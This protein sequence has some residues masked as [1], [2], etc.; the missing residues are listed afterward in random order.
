MISRR[1]LTGV[2][3]V[4][5]AVALLFLLIQFV[6][7]DLAS[8][9][10]GPRVTEELRATHAERIGTDRTL[11]EQ[12]VRFLGRAAR[13]RFRGRRHNR[14]ADPRR[15]TGRDARYAETRIFGTWRQL[16]AGPAAWRAGS[17]A[18]GFSR[19]SAISGHRR[20]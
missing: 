4:I 12:L 3:P 2:L 10:Y 14:P 16:G 13:G 5:G 19:R 15:D 8:V 7:G 17:G 9:L 6:P 18:A 1:A 20:G 11:P